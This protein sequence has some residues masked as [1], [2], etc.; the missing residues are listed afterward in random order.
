MQKYV[1]DGKDGNT[2]E[3]KSLA[4]SIHIQEIQKR[5][6]D[7]DEDEEE[8]EDDEDVDLVEDK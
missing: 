2:E 7:Q 8:D 6:R 1:G 3:A 5:L 4:K